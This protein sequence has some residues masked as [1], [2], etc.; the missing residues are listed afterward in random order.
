MHLGRRIEPGGCALKKEELSLLFVQLG[1]LP[2]PPRLPAASTILRNGLAE[3][4]SGSCIF[5]TSA[6]NVQRA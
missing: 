6:E 3:E 5:N 4:W 1:R 2:R